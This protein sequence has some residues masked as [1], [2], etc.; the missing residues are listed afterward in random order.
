MSLNKFSP[1]INSWLVNNYGSRRGALLTYWYRIMFLFGKYHAYRQIDWALIDRL[2]F[3][4]KG[5]ICRSAYAEAV[6]RS[7]DVEAVSC[8]INTQNGLSANHS[9]IMIANMKGV[10]L[11]GHKTTELQSLSVRKHDLLIAMEPWQLDCLKDKFTDNSCTL[12]GLWGEPVSPHIQDPY[13]ASE[14]YF[15]R[16]FCGIENSVYAIV[17][18]INKTS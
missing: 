18:K 15:H 16:C 13:G 2:V 12:L 14:A 1:K 17:K 10:D 9:A 3:V 5:N 7:L 11:Q 4:C 8:G 6:A